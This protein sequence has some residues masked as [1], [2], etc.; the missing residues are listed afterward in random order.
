MAKLLGRLYYYDPSTGK[1]GKLPV[2][3]NN[4]VT[5]VALVG[6]LCGQL[7]FGYLGDK[8]GR[9]KVYAITPIL[10]AI[11][12]ICSGLSFGANAKSVIGKL[13]FFRFWLGVLVET[14]LSLLQSCPSTPTKKLVEHSLPR[15]FAMQG[16]GIIFAGLVSM[17]LSAIFLH[18]YKAPAFN[19]D[20]VFSTQPQAD[21]LWRIVLMLGALPAILTYYW[22]MK[23]PETGRYTAIIEGNAKQAAANMG[24]VLDIELQV[25]HDKLAQFKAANNYTLFSSEFVRRHGKHF[26]GTTTTWFL[27]DIAFYSQN[28]A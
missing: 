10:M 23:M 12:A 7:I 27:L 26:I 1:P 20:Y 16:V 2:N 15:C 17:V 5:G 24:K 11:C 13:C 21:Y 25:E 19:V 9:K 3:V 8:L 18:A 28:L 22:R 6:T 14:I 4:A